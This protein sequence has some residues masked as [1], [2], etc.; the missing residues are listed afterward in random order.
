MA[1]AKPIS[2]NP[3]FW[4]PSLYLAEGLPNALAATVALILFQ[5]LGV[6]NKANTFWVG[7]LYLPWV[8]KPLWSPAV[9]IL[10]TRRVWIWQMQLFLAVAMACLARSVNAVNFFP[11]SLAFF[12]FVTLSSATH[13][14]AAD[15]FYILATSEREQSFFVGVRNTFYRVAMLCAQGPFIYYAAKLKAG[16]GNVALGW[17][18][19]F[20]T[21]AGLFLLF[22][23]YHGVIL[24]RPNADAPGQPGSLAKF[25]KEFLDT[26]K[27]FFQ[28]PGILALLSFLLLYRFGEAQLLKIAPLFLKAAR[29]DGGLG[30]TTEQFSVVY[31]TI[32]VI[33]MM[34]G[35]IVAGVLVSRKGL[36]AWIWPMVI[37]MHLPDAVFIYLSHARPLSL[38]LIASGVALEQFGYGFGFTAYMLYMIYIARGRHQTAHYAICTGFMAL[39]VMIPGMWSGWLQEL[40]GYQHFFVWVILA[41]IPSFLVVWFIPLDPEFGMKT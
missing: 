26:F 38:L 28:K 7:L 11:L 6:P 18:L 39:G 35:G 5:E 9:D 30:L 37:I 41:T 27:A 40:L 34:A 31:S 32:G 15:G 22:G 1:D 23:A 12:G 29:A 25:F 13:D 10:R 36:R 14:I 3:W 8:L 24:P 16:T 33:A 21:M 4:I 2:R 20:A 17:A 19:A